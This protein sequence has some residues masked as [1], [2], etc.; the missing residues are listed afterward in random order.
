MSYPHIWFIIIRRGRTWGWAVTLRS[1]AQENRPSVAG[2]LPSQ[3]W[4]ACIIA[5]AVA[6]EHPHRESLT[7]FRQSSAP[8]PTDEQKQTLKV[9]DSPF[10]TPLRLDSSGVMLSESRSVIDCTT[11]EMGFLIGTTDRGTDDPVSTTSLR[12]KKEG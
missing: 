3:W 4:R 5:I 6:V 12:A 9:P 7:L 2:L 11:V 8:A 10:W 1:R